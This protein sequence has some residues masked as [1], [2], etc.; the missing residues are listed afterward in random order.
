MR[1]QTKTVLL[2]AAI[3]PPTAGILMQV[4]QYWPQWSRGTSEPG[5]FASFIVTGVGLTIPLAYV[6]GLIPSV[7]GGAIYSTVLNY[8][9]VLRYR[10][11][12]RAATAAAIGALTGAAFG[13]LFSGT[14]LMF[15]VLGALVA[16]VVALFIPRLARGAV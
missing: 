13:Q 1:W 4:F 6:F 2:V 16:G 7:I 9:P 15:A 10:R 8:V 11:W 12:L 3:A 5:Q 14:P